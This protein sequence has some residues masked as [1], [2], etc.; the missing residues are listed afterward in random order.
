MNK[1]ITILWGLPGSGKTTYTKQFEHG[2]KARVINVDSFNQLT[3]A[4]KIKEIVEQVDY[5]GYKH[6]V[7]D[8]LLTLNSQALTL[9]KA[10]TDDK[11][12]LE[13]RS[14]EIVWWKED[15]EACKWNDRG[16]RLKTATIT[17]DNS[18]FEKPDLE[19]FKGYKVS[20]V[21]MKVVRKPD[22]LVWSHENG[23]GSDKDYDSSSWSLGGTSGSCYGGGLSRVRAE[24]QPVSFEGFDS[25]LEKVC[26]DITLLKYK[27][28]Y[29]ETVRIKTYGDSDCYGGSVEYAQ[30]SC[31]L[32]K[33]YGKLVEMELIQ[34]VV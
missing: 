20:L 26:P 17:I 30:Y 10:I 23:F 22:W 1:K 4:K 13:T 11:G 6:I 2:Q 12:D 24:V 15:R 16:R 28:L 33:L 27:K 9:M 29:A 32:E 31:D 25:L 8:S 18:P 14:F 5:S 3:P 21:S 19:Q 7:I 34:P